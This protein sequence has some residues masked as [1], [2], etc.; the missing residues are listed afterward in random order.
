[1]LIGVPAQAIAKN[2]KPVA[3]AKLEPRNDPNAKGVVTLRQLKGGGTDILVIARN[4]EPGQRYFSLYYD[5]PDCSDPDFSD[6]IGGTYTANRGG[7]GLTHGEAD[8]DLDEIH[9]VSVRLDGARTLQACA[10]IG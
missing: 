6:Q 2:A 5:T 8:D 7:I 4:L 3:V 1:M 10:E 9:S